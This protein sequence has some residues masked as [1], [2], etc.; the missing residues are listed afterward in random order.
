MCL[1]RRLNA[2][3]ICTWCA[4]PD[5]DAWLP[6]CLSALDELLVRYGFTTYYLLVKPITGNTLSVFLKSLPAPINMFISDSTLL[7]RA[8]G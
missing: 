1:G 4:T 7:R 3:G 2:F 6:F 5:T 8:H